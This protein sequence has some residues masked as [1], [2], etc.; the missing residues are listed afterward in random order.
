[1]RL[2]QLKLKQNQNYQRLSQAK[3]LGLVERRG[4]KASRTAVSYYLWLTW[5]DPEVTLE[6]GLGSQVR[7][8]LGNRV[9]SI[10]LNCGSHFFSFS[11]SNPT[12]PPPDSKSHTPS[13]IL[14]EIKS[15]AVNCVDLSRRPSP[16]WTPPNPFIPNSHHSRALTP[17]LSQ[18]LISRAVSHLLLSLPPPRVHHHPQSYV[19][20]FPRKKRPLQGPIIFG[21][22]QKN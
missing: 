15:R 2:M 12:S 3:P 4:G 20:T 10:L 17:F 22:P 21:P 6:A 18:G 8:G 5:T 7:N 1:M 19:T 16:T 9:F 14:F 13:Q 11:N